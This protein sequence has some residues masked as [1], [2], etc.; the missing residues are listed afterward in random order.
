M[1]DLQND[2]VA[3]ALGG[4]SSADIEFHELMKQNH[5]S[6]F[7][8]CVELKRLEYKIGCLLTGFPDEMGD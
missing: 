8:A 1:N 3:Y 2:L 4:G 5:I 7:D 6:I